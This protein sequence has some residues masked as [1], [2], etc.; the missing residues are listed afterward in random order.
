[1]TTATS[2]IQVE[3]RSSLNKDVIVDRTFPWTDKG[4]ADAEAFAKSVGG[5]LQ[6]CGLLPG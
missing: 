5:E 4:E 3:W 2:F 6:F 1:M